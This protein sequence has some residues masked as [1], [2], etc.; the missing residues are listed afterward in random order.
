MDLSLFCIL[1][2]IFFVIIFCIFKFSCVIFCTGIFCIL[3]THFAY[4]SAHDSAYFV[5]PPPP[6]TT[7]RTPAAVTGAAGQ[8]GWAGRVRHR[9]P[10]ASPQPAG[11]GGGRAARCAGPSSP[12]PS[13]AHLGQ[14]RRLQWPAAPAS[15]A[16]RGGAGRGRPVRR[17]C[18]P[19]PCPIPP[20]AAPALPLACA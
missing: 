13:P 11:Q 1:C 14:G 19:A 4:Y 20:M 18:L 15:G 8:R 16:G 9:A 6:T 17:A 12:P 2:V 10:P 7:T 3:N 5:P